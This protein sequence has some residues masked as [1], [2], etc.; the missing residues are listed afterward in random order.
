[1]RKGHAN[2]SSQSAWVAT[3]SNMWLRILDPEFTVDDSVVV[4][5]SEQVSYSSNAF[6]LKL[7]IRSQTTY[8]EKQLISFADQLARFA[9]ECKSGDAKNADGIKREFSGPCLAVEP[10]RRILIFRVHS[11]GYDCNGGE[12]LAPLEVDALL[13]HHFRGK[14]RVT[15]ATGLDADFHHHRRTPCWRL[16]CRPTSHCQAKRQRKD[17]LAVCFPRQVPHGDISL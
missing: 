4:E 13:V 8:C 6:V 17:R 5:T 14:M 9:Q 11:H 2:V 7:T 16:L 15:A 3:M 10:D 12:S 1:M